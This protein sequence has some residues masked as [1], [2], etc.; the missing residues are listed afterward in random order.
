MSNS[1][2]STPKKFRA[3][4][5][6]GFTDSRLDHRM[7]LLG[8]TDTDPL[9]NL[10]KP[11]KGSEILDY[12]SALDP[13]FIYVGFY[14]SYD[15]TQIIKAL[16]AEYPPDRLI[17]IRNRLLDYVR[18]S[19]ENITSGALPAIYLPH[20]SRSGIRYRL[21]IIEHKIFSVQ[22][23]SA[24]GKSPT[25]EVQD[26]SSFFQTSFIKALQNWNL[27]VPNS[28]IE[29][30]DNR[31]MHTLEYW[32]NNYQSIIEYNNQEL[33][34]LVDLMN[35]FSA[36]V[37]DAN[38]TPRRW[39]GPGSL[40]SK[41]L[42]NWGY[43]KTQIPADQIT[44]YHHAKDS[45]FGGWFEN[46]DAGHLN[47]KVNQ[48]DINSAYPYIISL[49]PTISDLRTDTVNIEKTL[50]N[51]NRL[52]IAIDGEFRIKSDTNIRFLPCRMKDGRVIN[53]LSVSGTMPAP[54]VKYGLENNLFDVFKPTKLTHMAANTAK[55]FP[56]VNDLYNLRKALGK[57]KKGYPIK[58]ALNSLYGKFAQSVGS[59]KYANPIYATLITS[60][61]RLK[62]L[63]LANQNDSIVMFATDAIFCYDELPAPI[64]DKLGGYSHE[65]WDDLIIVQSGFYFGM[66][67]GELVK[68]RTRG[69]SS[70]AFADLTW[71]NLL[72]HVA[73]NKGM[74]NSRDV[75][76]T[77]RSALAQGT[78]K[79]L[80]SLGN[81]VTEPQTVNLFTDKANQWLPTDTNKYIALPY[82]DDMVSY[83]YRPLIGLQPI[84]ENFFDAEIADLTSWEM[85]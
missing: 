61:T 27:P 25:I 30:K 36:V 24:L 38:L 19:A 57:D 59:P 16:L 6:E 49:L 10:T 32:K 21:T 81:F 58:L 12:I 51:N 11:L 48:Y 9:Y 47:K 65:I 68:S 39:I 34:S 1:S 35:E 73:K 2:I 13:K 29:G 41:Q 31:S 85:D 78:P 3:I 82:L 14:F 28:I 84:K 45:F 79:A 63:E 72:A 46:Y 17:A 62:L 75:L 5:S 42:S 43:P 80:N 64:N 83:P 33:V 76:H 69:M 26:V 18:S 54:L 67:N 77:W 66:K 53:P 20:P 52:A 37:I 15:V 56:L 7:Y 23:I 71:D 44:S 70:K 74:K 8:T 50:L 60:L 4:D 55:Q 40:A 22:R